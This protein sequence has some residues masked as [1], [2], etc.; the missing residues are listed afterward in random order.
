MAGTISA[1]KIQGMR[2]LK[3]AFQALP[4]ITRERLLEATELTAQEVV[5][6][7]KG[8]LLSSPSIRSRA[9]YNH[10]MY[11]ITKTNGRAR[12][13]VSAGS[14]SFVSAGKRIRLKGIIGTSAG[15]K[16]ITI[17]PTRYAHFVEYGTRHMPAEP[18]MIPAKD[19]QRAPYL[20]RVTHAWKTVEQDV[21]AIGR[22][23]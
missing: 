21:A 16:A 19:S 14:T 2:E 15:G 22:H 1:A 20:D 6:H 7:A 5:R 23:Q 9:L 4:A 10:I 13:G 12:V 8:H 18:F 17:Y 3:A 11:A